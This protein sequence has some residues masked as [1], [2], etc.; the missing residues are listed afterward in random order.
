NDKDYQSQK[1]LKSLKNSL[2]SL[3]RRVETLEKEISDIDH[4]LLM[5]YDETISKPGF[6][7]AY[8]DKKKELEQLMDKWE[9]LTLELDQMS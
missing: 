6:F 4:Q 5:N 7:D 9:K 3:E 1:K 2:N 8:Q